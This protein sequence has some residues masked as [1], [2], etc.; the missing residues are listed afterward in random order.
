MADDNGKRNALGPWADADLRQTARDAV[1]VGIDADLPDHVRFIAGVTKLI[2][3]RLAMKD[4]DF[5]S[6]HP[7]VFLLEPNARSPHQLLPVQARECA[8]R[9]AFVPAPSSCDC[10]DRL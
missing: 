7:A 6:K 10:T 5:D 2:R 1:G 4:S 3:K 8:L 9:P